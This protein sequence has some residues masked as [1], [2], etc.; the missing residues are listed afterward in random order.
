MIPWDKAGK[1]MPPYPRIDLER[2]QTPD[3]TLHAPG[4]LAQ[5]TEAPTIPMLPLDEEEQ[6]LVGGGLP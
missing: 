6:A 5:P 3:E 2:I 4:G 1:P